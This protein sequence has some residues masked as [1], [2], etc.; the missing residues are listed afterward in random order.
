MQLL[1]TTIFTLCAVGFGI[2]LARFSVN[3]KTLLD[4]AESAWKRSSGPAK[5]E[6]IKDEVADK[7]A[8]AKVA[9]KGKIASQPVESH[10]EKDREAINRIVAKR[11]AEK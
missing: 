11:G 2:F 4:H 9:I 1:R 6:H 8:D 10:S 7:V 3:G 5:V